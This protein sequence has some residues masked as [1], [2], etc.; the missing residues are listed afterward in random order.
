MKTILV[1]LGLLCIASPHSLA[2][3]RNV[4][5]EVFTN[6]HCTVCPGA[7]AALN[8]YLSSSPNAGRLR[9]IFYHTTF[10]YSDDQLSL[11]NTTEPNA[12]NAYYNGPTSTPNTFF[13][14]V[15]QGRTYSS[16]GTNLDARMSMESPME[17]L[18]SGSRNG[19]TVSVTASLKK[20][21]T[22]AATDLVAHFVAV[23][24]VSYVGRNGVAP[25]DY[26]MR[27]ML[28]GTTGTSFQ[29]DQSDNA[30][31]SA[32]ATLGTIADI[33][34]VGVVVFVQSTSTKSVYQ[35]EYISYASLTG[36]EERSQN[37]PA[38]FELHQN[39]PNP[40]NPSTTITYSL[41]AGS[42][43]TLSFVDVIGR[44]VRTL[45]YRRQSAGNH[46]VHFNAGDLPAGV[47]FYS[48]TAG[49]RTSVRKM[50]LLK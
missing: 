17:I 8:A 45:E 5:V 29:F 31:V 46:S 15:N 50:L 49:G 42:D 14:G 22:I 25:Q 37:T 24:N 40:F 6:S 47:Y 39:Y 9:F 20:T 3:G 48:L 35:S 7:H 2:S 33:S 11:A 38:T 12:R 30:S 26:V 23:E 27:K 16:F 36:I 21:G 28:T 10:P 19:N 34:K 44:E 32:S 41:D 1:I 43:V 13:D 4:L 18:L